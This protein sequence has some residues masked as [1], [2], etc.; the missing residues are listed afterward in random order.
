MLHSYCGLAGLGGGMQA[1]VLTL[2]FDIS[3]IKRMHA[4]QLS[5]GAVCAC[6]KRLDHFLRELV[7][8]T[9]TKKR[10]DRLVSSITSLW[11]DSFLF[12]S[13]AALGRDE[14]GLVDD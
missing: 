13:G 5:G 3:W 8:I 10:G 1:A 4:Q 9:A 12:G 14:G 2:H 11:L 6:E 7:A